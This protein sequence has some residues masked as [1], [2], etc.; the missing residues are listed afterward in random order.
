M[1]DCGAC[2]AKVGSCA[3]SSKDEDASFG[4]AS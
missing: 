3:D 1:Q 4:N 2:P